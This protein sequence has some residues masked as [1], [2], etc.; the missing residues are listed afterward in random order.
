MQ[1]G[2][3]V[4]MEPFASK[5]DRWTFFEELPAAIIIFH[6]A[7]KKTANKITKIVAI[8]AV[9][10]VSNFFILCSLPSNKNNN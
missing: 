9:N 4:M 5:K 7:I 8:N 1:K 10:R 3:L 6:F 2:V